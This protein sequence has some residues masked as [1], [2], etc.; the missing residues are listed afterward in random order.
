MQAVK[1]KLTTKIEQKE[2]E[3]KAWREQREWPGKVSEV[4]LDVL[5]IRREKEESE[6]G[7]DNVERVV[8]HIPKKIREDMTASQKQIQEEAKRVNE[9]LVILVN[10]AMATLEDPAGM[11]QSLEPIQRKL[12]DAANKAEHFLEENGSSEILDPDTLNANVKQA[13]AVEEKI[14][15]RQQLW[16]EFLQQKE[17]VNNQL[18]AARQPIEFAQQQSAKLLTLTE[19]EKNHAQLMVNAL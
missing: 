19:A 11:T 18:D 6:G 14:A 5:L 8:L 1:T 10:E 16:Q 2:A 13:K 12:A 7:P 4:T 3:L 17:V 15:K 9:T